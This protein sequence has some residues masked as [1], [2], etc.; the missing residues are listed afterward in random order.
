MVKLISQVNV[1]DEI[2]ITSFGEA[3]LAYKGSRE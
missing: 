2:K 3:T 1:S